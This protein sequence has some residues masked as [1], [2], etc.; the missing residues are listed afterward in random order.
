MSRS[1]KINKLLA[2]ISRFLKVRKVSDSGGWAPVETSEVTE[3]HQIFSAIAELKYQASGDGDIP[4]EIDVL[5]R[6]RFENLAGDLP[7]P[8][9]H[10]A[11]TME[12]V[13]NIIDRAACNAA[14]ATERLYCLIRIKR[15]MPKQLADEEARLKRIA[16]LEEHRVKRAGGAR[17]AH[18]H[19]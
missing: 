6:T 4:V 18:K 15:Y 3:M 1:Q 2:R 13:D 10:K 16:E 11:K 17:N 9:M 5:D 19:A 7:L 8:Y 12:E 14:M